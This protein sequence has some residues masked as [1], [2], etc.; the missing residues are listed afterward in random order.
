MEFRR[1]EK[2]KIL[3]HVESIID[4]T[5]IKSVFEALDANM[6][7]FSMSI[8]GIGSVFSMCTVK[9][10]NENTVLVTTR[11][12]AKTRVEPHYSEV[13]CIEVECN[14]EVMTSEHDDGGRWARIIF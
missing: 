11:G 1:I 13:E 9:K 8:K 10:I 2:Q 5:E 3:R 14:K 4:E 12:P 7:N 6:L